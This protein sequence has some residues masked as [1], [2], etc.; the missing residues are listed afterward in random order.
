ML[1]QKSV[2]PQAYLVAR[3][4]IGPDG[5]ADCTFRSSLIH[6]TPAGNPLARFLRPAKEHVYY[7]LSIWRMAT[8]PMA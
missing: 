3:N 1:P 4:L 7:L 5:Y 6:G 8:L 2:G